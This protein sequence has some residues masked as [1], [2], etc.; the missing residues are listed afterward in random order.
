MCF[1]VCIYF[2]LAR[3]LAGS[4]SS[5]NFALFSF[6]K[7]RVADK[8]IRWNGNFRI[9]IWNGNLRIWNDN[10]RINF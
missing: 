1:H 2:F 8:L 9:K 10:F 3:K 6:L 5:S 4:L 7:A